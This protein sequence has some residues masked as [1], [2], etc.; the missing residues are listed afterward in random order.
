MNMIVNGLRNMIL[1]SLAPFEI[2][3]QEALVVTLHY[4]GVGLRPHLCMAKDPGGS[5][6]DA[7]PTGPYRDHPDVP[8]H[9]QEIGGDTERLLKRSQTMRALL[10]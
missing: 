6:H 7:L 4:S 1:S 2:L 3:S 9:D 10:I 8:Y 5:H